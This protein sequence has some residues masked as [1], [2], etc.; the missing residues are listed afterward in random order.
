MA[1]QIS[2]IVTK[3]GRKIAEAFYAG[4]GRNLRP[5]WHGLGQNVTDALTS[6]DAAAAAHLLWDVRVVPSA[7]NIDGRYVD[8]N[9]FCLTVRDDNDFIL[10]QVKNR[11]APV[12][13]WKAFS[14]LDS[15][16]AEQ[17]LF[18]E[19]AGALDGGRRVWILARLPHIYNVTNDDVVKQY[20]LFV[21]HHDGTG[22][23]RCFPTS[24]R[25]VCQN[26]LSFA[27]KQD[28]W[29]G[30]AIRHVGDIEKKVEAARATLGKVSKVFADMLV[31]QQALAQR[32]LDA[33][34]FVK[35]IDTLVPAPMKDGK[36]VTEGKGFTMRNNKVAA[37]ASNFYRDPMQK[38]GGIENTA[39]AAFNAVTQHIDHDGRR[40]KTGDKSDAEVRMNAVMLGS[41][42]NEKRKAFDVAQEMFLGD[43]WEADKSFA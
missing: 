3:D 42:A 25:V 37:I 13:N 39:W 4:D 18:F 19:S 7:A 26:T 8:S 30:I 32:K 38:I 24:V 16:I 17:E 5:A 2:E 31:I 21:N 1:H 11:Y 27:L 40:R 34:D 29:D 35:Y 33:G 22:S 41:G 10:G 43:V 36:L 20:L 12:Q 23:V 9:E 28:G 14:F 15:L 6:Y